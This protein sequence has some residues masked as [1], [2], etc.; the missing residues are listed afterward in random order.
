MF[1]H[2]SDHKVPKQNYC[3]GR[4]EN[5]KRGQLGSVSFGSATR[6][7]VTEDLI[8]QGLTTWILQ[9]IHTRLAEP[10]GF[11]SLSTHALLSH[12]DSVA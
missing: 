1:A 8:F 4:E 11:C 7:H 2:T 5:A 9:P 6:L 10:H 12:V 3:F